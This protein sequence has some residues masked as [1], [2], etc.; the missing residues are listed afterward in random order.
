MTQQMSEEQVPDALSC[1]LEVGYRHIDAA[2]LYQN[3]D[4]VGAVLRQW[5]ASGRIKREDLFISTKVFIKR[6][7]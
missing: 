6:V 5:I 2:Y 1:A 7:L 4:S 3:E